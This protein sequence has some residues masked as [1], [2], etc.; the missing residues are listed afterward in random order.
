LLST[1]EL[2]NK[3]VIQ[4]A[5]YA[6]ALK[7]TFT[8]LASFYP[9]TAPRQYT[10]ESNI[11]KYNSITELKLMLMLELCRKQKTHVQGVRSFIF[12]IPSTKT[13][14]IRNSLHQTNIDSLLAHSE[15]L[16]KNKNMY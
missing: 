5:E 1:I 2:T 15:N 9:S 10:H 8:N 7:I 14:S 16:E 4:V 12:F 11:A 13:T 3:T 6:A